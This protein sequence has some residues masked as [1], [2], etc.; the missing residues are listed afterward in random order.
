MA[1][2][3]VSFPFR[4]SAGHRGRSSLFSAHQTQS[5]AERT[6]VSTLSFSAEMTWGPAVR[7][8]VR[9]EMVA[10]S[11]YVSVNAVENSYPPDNERANVPG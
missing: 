4:V 2:N 8:M 6:A 5:A 11:E 1:E 3:L 7:V 10:R 9:P